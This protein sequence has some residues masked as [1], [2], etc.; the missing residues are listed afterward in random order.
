MATLSDL[1]K[2]VG[3]PNKANID[4]LN[5]VMSEWQLLADLLF[6][7][8][9]LWIPTTEGGFVAAG[10]ARPSSAATV[11]FRD[12]TE[13]EIKKE[14]AKE[15]KAAFESG[16]IVDLK[17]PDSS[18]GLPTRLSAIPIRRK[19]DASAG[20]AEVIAVITRHTNLSESRTPNKLQLNYVGLGN[21]LLAMMKE[22][23]F[24]DFSTPTGPRRGAPRANDGLLRLDKD[25]IVT[26]AS[27]NGLSAFNR[28]GISGELEGR[29]LVESATK[30]VSKQST[31]DESL[32]LVLTGKAPWRTDLESA[33]IT[34][35]IRAI[36]LLKD[37]VRTGAIVLCREITELR[38]QERELLT[39]DATIREI[40]HRVKNNLQTVASLLRIQTRRTKSEAAKDALEQAI[41]RISA[42]A[43]VHNTLAEG[44]SQ[45]LNF[46]S[47]FESSMRLVGE[48]ASETS[49]KVNLHIEGKFGK[50]SSDQATPLA[51]ALTELVTN[52]ARHGLNNRGGLIAINAKRTGKQLNIEVGD[53][54]IGIAKDAI[55]SGLGTQIIKTLVEGELRGNIRWF[56]PPEGGTKVAISI[57]L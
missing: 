56:S 54:G 45:E 39:K 9:V 12:I 7:D 21:E 3:Y 16:E 28:L 5:L 47:V 22:G 2:S 48:L 19:P 37:G 26:F 51:V 31:V 27:P 38:R 8:L 24:P 34:L 46:D 25:G 29:S 17:T 11:F 44:F 32:P 6:A 50:L 41:R 55:G 49:G 33:S 53:N 30:I 13:S 43:L 23:S 1:V 52:A 14:W 4:W 42:I 36:P 18:I 15:V 35:S 20:E 10:H 57:P 40:H